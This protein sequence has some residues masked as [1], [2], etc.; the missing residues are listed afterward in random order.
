M[1][2]SRR[3]ALNSYAVRYSFTAST[4]MKSGLHVKAVNLSDEWFVY[5]VSFDRLATVALN[6]WNCS[7]TIETERVRSICSWGVQGESE[8]K[9]FGRIVNDKGYKVITSKLIFRSEIKMASILLWK[10]PA[11]LCIERHLVLLW[12][13]L[14]KSPGSKQQETFNISKYNALICSRS[15]SRLSYGICSATSQNF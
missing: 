1:F 12:A 10:E 7:Q 13:F 3:S 9:Y 11:K 14:P 15:F 8:T 6:Q 5:P 4:V 2:I